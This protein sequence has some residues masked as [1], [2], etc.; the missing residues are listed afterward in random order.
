M[1]AELELMPLDPL[2]EAPNRNKKWEEM[3]ATIPLYSKLTPRFAHTKHIYLKMP[4][5]DISFVVVGLGPMG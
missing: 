5:C 3:D 4:K 2:L 1:M